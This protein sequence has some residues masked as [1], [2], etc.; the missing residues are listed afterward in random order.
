MQGQIGERRRSNP[1]ADEQGR[2]HS[3]YAAW[4]NNQLVHLLKPDQ[5]SPLAEFIH[6]GFRSLVLNPKF[7]C[8]AAKSAIG[9]GT[10]RFGVYS[11]LASPVAT[12]GLAHDLCEFVSEQP[13]FDGFSTFVATFTGPNALDEHAF[14]RLLWTQL[15][16]LHDRDHVYHDWDATVS[17]DPD[18]ENFSWSFAG[19]AFFIVGLHPASSRWTRRFAWPTLV[20]NAHAQFEQLR[21]D[22]RYGRM[23]QVIRDRDR[24][25]QGDINAN[26]S[27]WGER[28]EARQYAGR[29]VEEA[30]RCPFH[31]YVA[32]SDP[33]EKEQG[34]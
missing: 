9:R 8:V 25:L 7:S 16:Q 11:D 21:A 32:G 14:E 19:R 4:Q 2:A 18:D 15:Q 12:A 24:A 29:P 17:A 33:Q 22:G 3:S 30:W 27:D 13:S 5:P 10:Y 31:A 6:D 28:S 20:F 34:R 23:Q 26:L 1:F